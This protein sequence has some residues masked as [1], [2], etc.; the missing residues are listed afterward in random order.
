M[1]QIR[2]KWLVIAAALMCVGGVANAQSTNI[3]ARITQS[4]TLTNLNSRLCVELG[5]NSTRE[6]VN[7]V[8]GDCA[9]GRGDWDLADV[10][11]GE[12]AFINRASGRVMDVENGSRADTA[13]VY[14]VAWNGAA[15]QRWRLEQSGRG[16]FRI[17]NAGSGKCLDVLGAS[18]SI[19][20]NIGQYQCHNE[21]NQ[22]WQLTA[23]QGNSPVVGGGFGRPGAG[24]V[25]PIPVA[26]ARPTGRT[27][28]S[29]MVLSRVS[30]KCADVQQGRQQE[31]ADVRQWSCTGSGSQIWDVVD[32]GNGEVAF[33]SQAGGRVMEVSGNVRQSG[34][35]VVQNSWNGGVNQRWRLEAVE[36][37]YSRIVNSGSG[38]CLDLDRASNVDGANI[39]QF[40]C[41][42]G[43]NQQ[44]RVEIRGTGANWA[45][46]RPGQNWWS[47]RGGRFQEEPP[48][49]M[50]GDFKGNN[51]FYQQEIVVSIYS[52]GVV[53]ANLDGGQQV[54]G[55]Y[56]GDQI[57]LG[58]S[59]YDIQQER[60]GFR[61]TPS[62]QAGQQG[63]LYQRVRYESPRRTR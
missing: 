15:S 48:A 58:N 4:G 38:K 22:Q 40:D 21:P 63:T 25:A 3:G 46:Y 31:F 27:L 41:H 2:S 53:V 37:G 7:I 59:R 55:Y 39:A 45:G 51:G 32:V 36:G 28:Y 26:G 47:S 50:V 60:A 44:W 61:L 10:G 30:G 1:K 9:S 52:D 57:H 13:N 5:Q 56:R 19:G 8:Q 29:G 49:Y 18:R 34:A 23:L 17:V 24:N 42:L 54:T 35:D 16:T 20:G 12:V 43:Q 6:G 14:Q 11:N 33:V 62:G